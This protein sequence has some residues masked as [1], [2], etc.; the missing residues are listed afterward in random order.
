MRR[1]G[2]N[3]RLWKNPLPAKDFVVSVVSLSFFFK[4]ERKR[5]KGRKRGKVS[6][7]ERELGKTDSK[8]LSDSNY[9][10][11]GQGRPRVGWE[12]GYAS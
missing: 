4:R 2:S 5:E 3:V 9:D 11:W 1:L 6:S 8:R 7:R 10:F 12:V